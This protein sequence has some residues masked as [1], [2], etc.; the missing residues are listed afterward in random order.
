MIVCM[1]RRFA[2][3]LTASKLRERWRRRQAGAI[4]GQTG[5]DTAKGKGTPGAL[6]TKAKPDDPQSWSS[7]GYVADR[8]RAPCMHTMYVDKPM[9]G[10][11]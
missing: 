8:L 7:C 6:E 5:V 4:K 10:M 3:P 2:S 1:S 9:Q 11:G